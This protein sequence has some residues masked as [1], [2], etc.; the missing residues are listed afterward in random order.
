MGFY[1][2]TPPKFER[3]ECI[4]TAYKTSS[5]KPISTVFSRLV[6]TTSETN[7]ATPF[8]S[9]TTVHFGTQTSLP[10]NFIN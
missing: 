9:P 8:S 6:G 10:F 5:Y 2:G 3:A 1:Y 7:R 4:K